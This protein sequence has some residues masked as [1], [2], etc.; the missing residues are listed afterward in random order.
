MVVKWRVGRTG[1]R[2]SMGETRREDLQG[3]EPSFR[4]QVEKWLRAG[5]G[6]FWIMPGGGKRSHQRQIELRKINGCPDIWKS[7]PST[8][9]VPTAIPGTS[10][11]ETGEAVDISGDKGL[12]EKLAP[13]FGL[14]RI[15]SED[16]HF[17]SS[18]G[19]AAKPTVHAG[20]TVDMD[21][22]AKKTQAAEMTRDDQCVVGIPMPTASTG[23]LGN[24]PFVPNEL[25]IPELCFLRRSQ[26]RAIIGGISLASGVAWMGV[27]VTLLV[28]IN[29]TEY[30]VG[31]LVSKA[32]G[33]KRAQPALQRAAAAQPRPGPR[34]LPA[35][36]PTRIRA[37]IKRHELARPRQALPSGSQ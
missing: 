30:A 3:L 19:R 2:S 4:N 24:L 10:R 11:H 33:G 28:G 17:R 29:I 26:A 7:S 23:V 9:R 27:G 36:T 5:E 20:G 1:R 32:V 8:C 18:G 35:G 34:S 15:A 22:T 14:E 21:T 12:A 6:A 25:G 16:W 31:N 37:R 13:L